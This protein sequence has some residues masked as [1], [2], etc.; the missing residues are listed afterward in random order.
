MALEMTLSKIQQEQG[1][2]KRVLLKVSGEALMGQKGYGIDIEVVQ[3]IA[4]EICSVHALGIQIAVVVGGGNIF[5]G[6]EGAATGL[7][8]A[9]ADYMGMLATAMN[10]LALHSEIEKL[11]VTARVVSGLPMSNVCQTYYQP[12]CLSHLKKNRVVIFVGGSGNP[13]FTTD[14]AAALRAS[15]M[16]CD[17][18]LKGTQVDG[19]Y[20]SDPKLDKNAKRYETLTY[21]DVLV[22]NLK[23]MDSAA[24]ALARENR[25]PIAVFS[26]QQP[27]TLLE[28][29]NNK[30]KFT[31]ILPEE[32]K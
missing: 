3:R 29:V 5:R 30:G 6:L 13:Y 20:S 17:V 19:V 22:H 21:Q 25:I 26:I 15:E 16:H 27:G 24:I 4:Q 32:P 18:I 23:V 2:Y 7:D 31:L 9:T 12:Q 11:G 8:R 14:T 1:S 28:I 10:G